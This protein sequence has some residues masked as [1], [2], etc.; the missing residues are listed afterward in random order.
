VTLDRG[1]VVGDAE[2]HRLH[3]VGARGG[4]LVHVHHPD[5]R[6]DQHGEADAPPKAH[7]RLDLGQERRDQV[8]VAGAAHLRDHDRVDPL[9]RLL[10]DVHEVA[11]APVR[12]EA[13]DPR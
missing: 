4:D 11:V 1:G 6:L 8:H 13:V 10:D 5:R 3:P 2:D 7:R 12:V 9:A